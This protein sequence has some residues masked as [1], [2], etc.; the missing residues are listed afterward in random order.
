MRRIFRGSRG[1][2]S[3]WLGR[4]GFLAFLGNRKG[5][6]VVVCEIGF[7]ILENGGDMKVAKEKRIFLTRY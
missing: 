3:Y 7:G 1:E 6:N 5:E 4:G 2:V